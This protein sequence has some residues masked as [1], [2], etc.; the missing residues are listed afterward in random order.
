[1]HILANVASVKFLIMRI[2]TL[3]NIIKH[4]LKL[5]KY[6]VRS[7]IKLRIRS[8]TQR[9]CFKFSFLLNPLQ[10]IGPIEYQISTY[11]EISRV[12]IVSLSLPPFSFSQNEAPKLSSFCHHLNINTNNFSHRKFIQ[13]QI[14]LSFHSI[15]F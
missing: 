13:T 12:Q 8:R 4:D 6:R 11:I 14:L 9:D 2:I 10:V 15:R 1:M 7:C 5:K 3:N